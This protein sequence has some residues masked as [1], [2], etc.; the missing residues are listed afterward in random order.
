MIKKTSRKK[1]QKRGEKGEQK[2]KTLG[3]VPNL[4]V[5]PNPG[6][7]WDGHLAKIAGMS[8]AKMLEAILRAAEERLKIK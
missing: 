5:N 6:W 8:Y 1:S 4:E 7:C 3:P 2:R